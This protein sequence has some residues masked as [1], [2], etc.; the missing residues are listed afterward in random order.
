M[1]LSE[2]R[3]KLEMLVGWKPNV[4][5]KEGLKRTLAWFSQKK[6]ATITV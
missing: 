2:A 3:A 4:G 1:S 6:Q 5:F